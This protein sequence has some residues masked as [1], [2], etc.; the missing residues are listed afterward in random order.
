MTQNYAKG[1]IPMQKSVFP[2]LLAGA[3]VLL[4]L[5]NTPGHSEEL[6]LSDTD[7]SNMDNWLCFGGDGSKDV[8]IF[9]IYPTVTQSMETAD[10]PYV[11][12]GSELMRMAATGWMVQTEGVVS[13][14]ANMYMPLYRQLNGVELDSLTSKEFESFTCATPRDDIFAAFNYYL[15][16]VNK[17]DRPFILYGHSQGSQLV[18]ELA[19]VF[20]G[21]EKYI[22]HNRNHIITY[23]IGCSVTQSQIDKN[24]NLKFSQ[25]KDDIGVM[26]S[27]N[28]TAPSE[29]ESEAYKEFG[30]WKQGALVTNPLTWKTDEVTATAVPFAGSLPGPDGPMPVEGN[31]DATVDK[32]RGI[33]VITTVDETQYIPRSKKIGKF[34]GCD[35]IFFMDSIRQ[36][37]Q[38]R[39]AAFNTAGN[40]SGCT[41]GAIGVFAMIFT[42]IMLIPQFH[43]R[44][45]SRCCSRRFCDKF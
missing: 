35:V 16:N 3:L 14:A 26:V 31:A 37:I 4:L 30:T 44:N 45:I 23:A 43:K 20:L 29:I 11:R 32:E 21:N 25:S 5:F 42:V 13:G 40:N 36:N 22:Q 9:V 17:G 39:I 28:S 41:T 12:L 38:G 18:I 7:Y 8:D 15:T 1:L 33:L 34:H 27:W 10:R 24:P 6:K 19:T 2:K